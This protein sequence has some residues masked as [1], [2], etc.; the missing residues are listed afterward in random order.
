MLTSDP[1]CLQDFYHF[2]DTL[3]A[4]QRY[5]AEHD[6]R[7]KWRR[8]RGG[9]RLHG[10]TKKLSESSISVTSPGSKSKASASTCTRSPGVTFTSIVAADAVSSPAVVSSQAEPEREEGDEEVD[11]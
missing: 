2:E 9:G 6:P 4:W 11:V 3:L 1:R 10:L 8:A 5:A 7:G